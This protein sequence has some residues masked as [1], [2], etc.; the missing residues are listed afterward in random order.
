MVHTH[1]VFDTG[2][3]R[4]KPENIVHKE[5]S[6]PF[7]DRQGLSGVLAEEGPILWL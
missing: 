6:C 5:A 3:G 4:K 1:L 7:C 2:I